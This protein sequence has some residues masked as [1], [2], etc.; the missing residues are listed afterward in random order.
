MAQEAL[1]IKNKILLYVKANGPVLPVNISKEISGNTILAGA[2]LSQLISE[3]S[4]LISHAKVGGSPL[5]YV[6]GQEEKLSMLSEYMNEKEKK[7]FFMIKQNKILKD[8]SLEP[9]QR[10]AMRELKDF[11]VMLKV[12]DS[13]KNEEIIW[14]W[15]LVSEEESQKLIKD[16]LGNDVPIKERVVVEAQSRLVS[17][18]PKE[19]VREQVVKPVKESIVEKPEVKV[20]PLKEEKKQPVKTKE[21][22]SN[23]RDLVNKYFANREISL[24]NEEMIKK[25]KEF[26]FT[27]DVNSKVGDVRFFIKA[28][29]KKKISDGDLLLAQS[30]AH[31]KRLP[32][33]FLGNGELSKKGKEHLIKNKLIFEN[34]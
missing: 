34:V 24:I 2:I 33:L 21:I 10:V 30:Q 15:H 5:Y 8:K 13:N 14:K 19:I 3:K 1:E 29:D 6:K 17:E 32:L 9:W 26:D 27:A 20:E 16:V 23:F 25:N 7:A 22:G 4:I 31:L 18:E 28:R 12:I 11:A